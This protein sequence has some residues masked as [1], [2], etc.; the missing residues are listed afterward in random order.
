MLASALTS[1]L[2]ALIFAA[3][4]VAKPHPFNYADDCP[5]V[6]IVAASGATDSKADRDPMEEVQR[7]AWSNWVGNITEPAGR[8]FK[9]EP[10]TIGWLYVPYPSTYGLSITEVPTYQ[11]ST[12]RGVAKAHE[13]LGEQKRKCG[14]RTSF[15]LLGY[16]VGGEVMERVARE[17]GTRGA[18]A[19]VD[20]DD[21][22]GVVLVGDPY[23][24]VG[25]PSYDGQVPPGG[26]FMSS[27]PA[28]YGEL[29]DK[30]VS[31]C[32]RWDIACDA[33]QR[34][35]VLDLLLSVLGQ[36]HFTVLDPLQT[37]VDADAVLTG[38]VGRTLEHIVR[39]PDWFSSQETLLDIVR[40]EADRTEQ[41][42][43]PNAPDPRASP[44]QIS[45]LYA[46]ATG[47]GAP[48]V[49]EK[50]AAEGAGFLADNADFF[51]LLLQPYIFVAFAQHVL[52]W[53]DVGSAGSDADH[54]V[55]WLADLA[56]SSKNRAPNTPEAMPVPVVAD[57]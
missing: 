29:T 14:A 31:A 9:D 21:V 30:I 24:P 48:I 51:E 39:E 53:Y 27:E 43:D 55:S 37:F 44:E 1:A 23:R 7:R 17:I 42:L 6:M 5:D 35:A 54:L 50:L 34:I 16:S 40:R 28:D 8:L 38:I 11:E 15:V 56:N 26:G 2:V 47:E 10:G 12:A 32:R 22:L 49:R 4:A 20:P 45:R 52:Y 13:L 36:I 46:W 33:P 25:T 57:P 3:P 18:K 19:T 41:I